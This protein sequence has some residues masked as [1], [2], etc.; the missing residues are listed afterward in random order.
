MSNSLYERDFYAWANEQAALLRAGK[1]DSADIENI[2]EEIESMGRSEKRELV[3]RLAVLLLHLLKWQFQ[4]SFRSTSWRLTVREQRFRLGDHLADNPSLK[5][6]VGDAMRDAYR[7]ARVEAARE[8][9]LAEDTF[10][11]NCPFT[12]DQATNEDFLPD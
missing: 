3:N 2:A 7:L 6:K 10:P 12:F 5:S 4:P 11:T 9:G 1:L 8:T